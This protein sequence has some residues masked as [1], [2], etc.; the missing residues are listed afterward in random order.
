M[1]SGYKP[2]CKWQPPFLWGFRP[3]GGGV[4]Q[5]V[6]LPIFLKVRALVIRP[7]SFH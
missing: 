1:L 4:E 5:G 6:K 2:V 3:A 7:R